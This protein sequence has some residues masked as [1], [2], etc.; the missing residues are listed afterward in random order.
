MLHNALYSGSLDV[1]KI[2]PL[3]KDVGV[4]LIMFMIL[5]KNSNVLVYN[6][7]SYHEIFSDC[8][9]AYLIIKNNFTSSLTTLL[10]N[11]VT[12]LLL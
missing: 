11:E 3:N 2:K 4:Y 1:G 7:I 10:K 6:Y 5:N 9:L 8:L 12:F